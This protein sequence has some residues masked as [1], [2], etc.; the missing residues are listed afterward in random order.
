MI[1][2]R[3]ATRIRPMLTV[4]GAILILT[5][6][7]TPRSSGHA[8]GSRAIPGRV[9]H[10]A[11]IRGG[12]GVSAG[13]TGKI[14]ALLQLAVLE[15]FSGTY[16]L[17]LNRD[18]RLVLTRGR[19]YL[20]GDCSTPACLA[21]ML[22]VLKCDE[23]IHGDVRRQGDKLRLAMRNV[24]AGADGK[25][26]IRAKVNF[27]FPEGRINHYIRETASAL[28]RPGYSVNMNPGPAFEKGVEVRSPEISTVTRLDT[29]IF[30]FK[31]VNPVIAARLSGWKDDVEEAD[32]S[33]E[34]GA[35]ERSVRLYRRLMRRLKST[36]ARDRWDQIQPFYVEIEKRLAAAYVRMFAQRLAETDRVVWGNRVS[37]LNRALN[38]YRVLKV[39]IAGVE[40][41][42]RTGTGPIEAAIA[43]RVKLVPLVVSR[44][45]EKLGN[46]AYGAY[47]FNEAL[48]YMRR[49]VAA[50]S[51]VRD[52]RGDERIRRLRERGE[53]MAAVRRQFV[54]NRVYVLLAALPDFQARRDDYRGRRTL[55]RA[56]SILHRE[57]AESPEIVAAL[58]RAA[59]RLKLP[60]RNAYTLTVRSDV[61]EA[62]VILNG[63]LLGPAPVTVTLL[64]G[65]YRLRVESK[66]YSPR[67]ISYFHRSRRNMTIRFRR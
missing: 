13:T 47:R 39:E 44:T 32:R 3:F 31:S 29:N 36:V 50:A 59:V 4:A 37:D 2:A 51:V 33:C 34:E 40:P 45:F 24:T 42:Y 18:A 8:Q 9:L 28:M 53:L 41:R 7:M 21:R 6:P 52:A 26:T 65:G 23:I 63:R 48:T 49:G 58:N 35:C 54:N 11:V 22:R 5:F 64:Q 14:R 60:V 27:A 56:W 43:E 19:N 30:R 10:V 38:R 46:T 55:F 25:I 66:G 17:L 61:P 57:G 62:R 16:R 67:T 1:M 20:S 12:A 15:K